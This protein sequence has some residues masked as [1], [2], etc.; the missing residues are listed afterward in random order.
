MRISGRV[1]LSS[2]ERVQRLPAPFLSELRD[3]QAALGRRGRDVVDL[4]R[5]SIKVPLAGEATASK[6]TTA[7]IKDVF[8]EYLQK[9]H[10]VDIDPAREMLILPG[11]RVALL[12]LAAYLADQD[13][14]FYLPDPGYE[15]YRVPA[16]L[17]GA[18]IATYPLYHRSDY[19]PNL[20][21]LKERPGKISR[22]MVVNS[23]HNP[24]GAVCDTAFYERLRKMAAT[25]NL[26]IV[27]D[28][29]YALSSAGNLRPEL[30]CENTRRL[31]VGLELLSF[32]TGLCAPHIKL[33]ALVGK[34][35]LI[36]PLATLSKQ[37]S[38]EPSEATVNSVAGYFASAKILED[39]I[40]MCREEI[41]KRTAIIVERLKNEGIEYYPVCHAGFVWIKLRHR[42]VSLSFAR[43]LLRLRGIMVAPRSAFGEQGEGWIRI[44][45]NVDS[46]T[47]GK[48]MDAIVRHYQPIRSQIKRIRHE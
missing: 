45:A 12:I 23:P 39:H 24:T 32:S 17:F 31:R 26:L 34:K 8:S 21:S 14:V 11:A 6:T 15:A 9:E 22:V 19:L 25:E 20:E 1:V 4:G 30:F 33:T 29:S 16:L 46:S 18:K 43:S 36:Q 5:Y 48:S 3:L 42:R 37:L 38:L 41:G 13:T 47:L 44:S 40:N 2:A 28:S 7:Q 27:A 35:T 10:G